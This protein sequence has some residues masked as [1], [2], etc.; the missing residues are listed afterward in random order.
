MCWLLSISLDPFLALIH[1]ALSWETDPCDLHS[2]QF[3]FCWLLVGYGQWEGSVGDRKGQEREVDYFWLIKSTK[4]SGKT[5]SIVLAFRGPSNTIT[6]SSSPSA[7]WVWTASLRY[8]FLGTWTSLPG[9][10]NP[11]PASVNGTIIWIIEGRLF[12]TK[13]PD[14]CKSLHLSLTNH[15]GSVLSHFGGYNTRVQKIRVMHTSQTTSKKARWCKPNTKS[16]GYT[17]ATCTPDIF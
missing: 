14:W 4:T 16:K 3:L 2:P 15:L 5:S 9:F 10:L 12:P 6:S 1:S 11:A 8:Q 13:D 17:L 7:P